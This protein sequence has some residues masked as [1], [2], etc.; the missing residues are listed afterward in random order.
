MRMPTPTAPEMATLP[1]AA[2]A[3]AAAR[4]GGE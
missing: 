1:P 4:P 2:T 3:R